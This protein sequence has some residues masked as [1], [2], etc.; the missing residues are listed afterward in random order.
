MEENSTIGNINPEKLFISAHYTDISL[1][2]EQTY[3][4]IYKACKLG[5]WHTL[6]S[7]KPE[8]AQDPLYLSLLRKEFEIGSSLSHSNIVQIYRLETIKD[9]GPSIVMEF[10]DGENLNIFLSHG[11]SSIGTL[12]KIIWELCSALDYLHSN[13][14]I[15]R[16]LKLEN[17]LIT[18]N[19]NNV[20][21]ID[22]G[23]S[24]SDSYAI[25]KQS[26]GTPPYI[27][28]EQL[29]GINK[30]DNRS[31]IYSLGIL[32]KTINQLIGKNIVKQTIIEKCT[33][34]DREQRFSSVKNILKT[35]EYKHNYTGIL[36]FGSILSTMLMGYGLYQLNIKKEIK[37]NYQQYHS[38]EKLKEVNQ[39]EA[40]DS[41]F[42]H[43]RFLTRQKL[44]QM[45]IKLLNTTEIHAFMEIYPQM[46]V[47]IYN[48]EIDLLLRNE[49]QKIDQA[50]VNKETYIATVRDVVVSEYRKWQEKNRNTYCDHS[51]KLSERHKLPTVH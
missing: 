21:L 45:L 18:R 15:H 33:Q 44:D 22:F 25:L 27:S 23:L 42:Q 46:D 50:L 9:I 48:K 47:N 43:A 51:A 35:L 29:A 16:D 20:K 2:K 28:P 6:K 3:F 37:Y 31:D 34:P 13:Q 49:A 32:F 4:R 24:D 36:I 38:E 19:G 8:F 39:Q 7:L 11:H 30:I 10:I 40:L 26:A 17:I 14:I 5:K 12:K 41:L 1:L